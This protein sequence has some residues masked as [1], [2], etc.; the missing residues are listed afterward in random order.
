VLERAVDVQIT[1]THISSVDPS[2]QVPKWGGTLRRMGS[3]RPTRLQHDESAPGQRS[4][5]LHYAS[6]K[7]MSHPGLATRAPKASARC[8]SA[9][10]AET[11]VTLPAASVATA[12]RV[13]SPLPGAWITLT[14]SAIPSST[15][16]RAAPSRTTTTG[17]AN[18]SASAATRTRSTNARAAPGRSRHQPVGR[19]PTTFAASIRS[20]VQVSPTRRSGPPSAMSSARSGNFPRP[21]LILVQSHSGSGL[22][23]GHREFEQCWR[24]G[25]HFLSMPLADR[26]GKL[27]L[28]RRIKGLP[29]RDATPPPVVGRHVPTRSLVK[30]Q[31]SAMVVR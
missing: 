12:M 25:G 31:S 27:P 3:C 8:R 5:G 30:R 26:F 16:Q 21:G 13:S 20:T 24:N 18:L 23:V 19:D 22:R 1:P 29:P 4:L 28:A 10:S 7:S 17:P 6:S 2:P 14:P 15:P 9:R 11:S